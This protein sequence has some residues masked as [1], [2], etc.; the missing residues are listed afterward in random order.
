MRIALNV[1][2]GVLITGIAEN[3]PA[4]KGGIE[5]GDVIR[6][7][8]GE[9]VG[10][11]ADLVKIIRGRPNQKVEIELLRQG[12]MKKISLTL[13]ELEALGFYEF[14][15]KKPDKAWKNIKKYLK[16][17][18]PFWEK[19]VDKYQEEMKRLKE[20]MKELRQ[21]LNALK[22]ELE[23]KLKDCRATL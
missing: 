12:K 5:I 4:E 18:K 15:V 2:N 11:Q 7:I 14:Q 8:A 13:G 17:I 21:E 9:E 22:K 6:K 3:S 19:G 23:E 16:E 10:N 1:G 20:E